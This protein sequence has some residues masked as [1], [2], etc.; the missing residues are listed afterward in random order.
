MTDSVSLLTA[1][2][3]SLRASNKA[4]IEH[5]AARLHPVVAAVEARA[6]LLGIGRDL[7]WSEVTNDIDWA[8]LGLRQQM[9]N[10]RAERTFELNF[11]MPEPRN[12][13]NDSDGP[14]KLPVPAEVGATLPPA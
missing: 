7:L 5:A 6:L 9:D 1:E 10:A 11:P 13:E 4:L 14:M 3:V 2:V 12:Y 8:R